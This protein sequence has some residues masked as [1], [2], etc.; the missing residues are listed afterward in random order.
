MSKSED[1]K[2]NVLNN[3]G[4]TIVD[5]TNKYDVE[6]KISAQ[7]KYKFY[8]QVANNQQKKEFRDIERKYNKKSSIA[9]R[10]VPFKPVSVDKVPLDFTGYENLRKIN[11]EKNNTLKKIEQDRN[12]ADPDFYKGLGTFFL[13]KF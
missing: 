6:K 7:D 4:K 2:T 13:K 3:L 1:K 8:K 10:T 11:F 12:K 5:L 9:Q